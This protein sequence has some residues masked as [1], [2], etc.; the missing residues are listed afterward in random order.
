MRGDHYTALGALLHDHVAQQLQA[1]PVRQA[2]VGNHGVKALF[3]QLLARLRQ[4]ARRFNP[5]A[6]TQQ[7]EFIKSAQIRLIVNDQDVCRL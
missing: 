6:L 1:K 5:V 2:H 4:V 7:G 3:L